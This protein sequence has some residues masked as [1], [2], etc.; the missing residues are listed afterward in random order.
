M[1]ID[2]IRK[3]TYDSRLKSKEYKHIMNKIIRNAK[4]GRNY[5]SINYGK[6]SYHIIEKLRQEGYKVIEEDCYDGKIGHYRIEW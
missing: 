4:M 2:E 6:V 1:T 5:F 3:I